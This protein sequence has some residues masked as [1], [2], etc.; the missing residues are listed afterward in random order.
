M[1]TVAEIIATNYSGSEKTRD[2]VRAQIVERFGEEEGLRYDPYQN[3]RT[4]AQWIKLGYRVKKA[5][6]ALRS[7]TLLSAKNQKGE[8]IKIPRTVCLFY[9]LQVERV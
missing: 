4:Y 9:Q 1:N 6:T 7:T 3:C 2:A 8:M 5:Q